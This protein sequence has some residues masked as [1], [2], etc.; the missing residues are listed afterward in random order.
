LDARVRARLPH[1]FFRVDA[2]MPVSARKRT[3][4]ERRL[5]LCIASRGEYSPTGAQPPRV[6]FVVSKFFSSCSKLAMVMFGR[7]NLEHDISHAAVES[8]T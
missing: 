8:A 1:G 3:N 2:R 6:C 4:D 5:R 7:H